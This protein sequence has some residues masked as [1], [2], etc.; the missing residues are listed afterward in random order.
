[1]HFKGISRA[2]IKKPKPKTTPK[3]Q[4]N[5][6]MFI[7]Q[8]CQLQRVMLSFPSERCKISAALAFLYSSF[9]NRRSVKQVL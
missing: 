4:I 5:D 8:I 1:M 7:I 9:S 2:F 6:R 3:P